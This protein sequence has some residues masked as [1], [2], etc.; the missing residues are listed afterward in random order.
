[1]SVAAGR[2]WSICIF[3]QAQRLGQRARPFSNSSRRYAPHLES[4]G[5]R[6]EQN[7][8]V[9]DDAEADRQEARLMEEKIRQKLIALRERKKLR[10][11]QAALA[12][13]RDQFESKDS[14]NAEE[15]LLAS[16]QSHL[17]AIPA[18]TRAARQ[19]GI[20]STGDPRQDLDAL[21]ES[22]EARLHT[23]RQL[24]NPYPDPPS[25]RQ[26]LT[27]GHP[28]LYEA[29]ETPISHAEFRERLQEAARGRGCKVV[30]VVLRAR[31][32]TC[33]TPR[34]IL[35]ILALAMQTPQVA[36]SLI[37]LYEP[38]M[39][40][41]YRCR[42]KASDREVLKTLSTIVARFRMSDLCV[43]PKLLFMALKF[44]ARA[45]SLSSM[46]KYLRWIRE[47]GPGMTRNVYRSVIAKFSIGHRGLGEIRNGRWRRS[48]LR[49]VLL[50]FDDCKDLPP[51]QQYHFGT[52]LVR[53]DW[54]YLHGWVAVL[55][56]CKES[57]EIWKEWLLWKET[58]AYK[59]PKLLIMK[60]HRHIAE[61]HDIPMTNKSRGSYWFLEQMSYAGDMRKAWQILKDTGIEFRTLK[62]RVADRLL[63]SL[64]H[65][66][67]WDEDVRSAMLAKYDRDL[68]KIEQA[69]GVRWT[70]G[71]DDGG[72]HHELFMDQE[73][74]L[75]RLS[76]QDWKLDDDYGYPCDTSPIVSMSEQ[77]LHDAEESFH[78]R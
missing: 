70:A 32:L 53:D 26:T 50:G 27:R 35:R 16:Q 9:H 5:I 62:T 68:G 48:E 66:S 15:E 43:E 52:F 67:E 44:A 42:T 65:A 59:K 38:I 25:G 7:G 72:G 64:E 76:E 29:P 14:Q 71:A 11:A 47:Q 18:Q 20:A 28:T 2:T 41:L 69:L 17:L 61:S 36:Q 12:R 21:F 51:E 8:F 22:R 78:S 54:Q 3:C 23:I 6:A 33:E 10:A 56:R 75:E 74:A 30:R 58:D 46:Q 63:E 31:L 55:A 19:S 45:R 13:A 39:R 40:A 34:D 49:Q 60:E 77:C 24:G 4:I 57:E 73:A 37:H 1:M